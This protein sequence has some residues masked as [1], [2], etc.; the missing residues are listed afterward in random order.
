MDGRVDNADHYYSWPPHCGG[1][2]DNVVLVLL[3][4]VILIDDPADDDNKQQTYCASMVAQ[5]C[6]RSF[7]NAGPH[8]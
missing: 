7:T 4:I 6:D 1:P 2:A 5:V 3:V 8:L